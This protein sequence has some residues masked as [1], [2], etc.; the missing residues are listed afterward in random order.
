MDEHS[1]LGQ[2]STGKT[3]VQMKIA[4]AVYKDWDQ[5]LA[6]FVYDPSGLLYKMK[7]GIPC[8]IMTRNKLHDRV[9]L[10][11]RSRIFWITA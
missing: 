2:P 1:R 3:T 10:L 8:R 4:Y 7:H 6:A 5:V 11:M 9:P